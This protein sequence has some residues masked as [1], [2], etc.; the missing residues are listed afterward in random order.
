[1]KLTQQ[2]RQA[3][4]WPGNLLL[5]ACPGSGKTRTIVAKL[6]LELERVRDTPFMVACITYTNAAIQEIDERAV[7]FLMPGDEKNFV[8]STIHSF[9]L[10]HI[11]RPFAS[12][13]PGFSGKMQVLNRDR[14]EFEAIASYAAEQVGRYDLTYNDYE[15]F[16]GLGLDANGKLSGT[17]L[18]NEMI[19]LAAPHF[20]ARAQK[21][22]FLDFANIIYKALRLLRDDPEIAKSLATRFQSFLIDEF[23]DTTDVQV[24]IFKAIHSQ[25]KSRFFLVGDPAQ[26]IFGFA[27]ARP[28]LI[29]PFADHIGANRNM[30]LSANFRSCPAIV[31]HAERL[32]PRNPA[33]TS[34]GKTKSVTEIPRFVWTSNT[35]DALFDE[36]LPAIERL[37]LPL[38]RC[39]VLAK[40]WHHLY[41]ISRILREF[42]V[43]IVGPGARPYRRSRLF[44]HLAEQLGGAVIDG[45]LFR[46]RNLERAIFHAVQDVTGET[47]SE[48]F[49]YEGRLS[50]VRL[51]RIAQQL[52]DENDGVAWLEKMSSAAGR[53]LAEGGW[54][55]PD[56]APLF[57]SSVEEMKADMRHEKIDLDNLSINDLGMFASPDRALRLST[58]HNAKGHEYAGVAIIGVKEGTIPFY[59]ARTPTEIA[60]EKRLFYVGVTR[61]EQVLL[62]IADRDR[63]GNLPSRFLGP[64]GVNIWTP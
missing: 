38:G 27:G 32:F 25:G 39:A 58:I 56:D 60:A 15:A 23:Q 4:E 2:Q 24:E 12:R 47:R 5:K 18:E 48:I 52:A 54:I 26:S 40:A 20:W 57:R 13:V 9:C 6:I 22:G 51:M 10:H 64:D 46:M 11:L 35:I 36:F 1:M 33:M 45:H 62:Y 14:P 34:E 3:V 17:A 63:F 43:P 42:G 7:A 21:L 53:V 8:V 37:K 59:R 31:D 44:A 30:S 50:T 29:D 16:A 19:R 55:T 41:P 61:A 28:E 49:G